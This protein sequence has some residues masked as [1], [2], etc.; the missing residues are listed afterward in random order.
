MKMRGKTA[1]VTGAG[2]GIGR[3]IALA[4][5]REGADVAVVARTGSE[6]QEVAG[7]VGAMGRKGLPITADLTDGREARRAVR[8]AI[9]GLGK[10]DVLVN[11]AGGYRLFTANLAHDVPVLQLSEEEWHRV[12]ASNLTTAFLCCKAV[13]PHMVERGSGVIINMSSGGVAR[14]GRAGQAAYSAAKA[15]VERLTES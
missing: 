8:D 12:L 9:G 7:E 11:N 5:A 1:L 10:V 15:A 6:V 4:Y 2:R 3:A 14:Q 13:L